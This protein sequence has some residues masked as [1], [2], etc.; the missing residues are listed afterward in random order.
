MSEPV[1]GPQF[2]AQ[3]TPA[4]GEDRNGELLEKFARWDKDLT[5][6]WSAWCEEAKQAYDFVA[7]HQWDPEDQAKME[8]RGKVAVVFN[9]T[10]PTLDAVSGAEIQNRQQ[11]QYYPREMGDTGVSDALTQ[12]AEYVSDECNGDQ[13]DSEAFRDLL[14]CGVGWTDTTPEV[15]GEDT[16]IVKERVDPLTVKADPASRKPCFEDARYIKREYPMSEDE[17]E[18]FRAEIGKPDA[19]GDDGGLEPGKRLTVVNPRQRYTNGMLGDGTEDEVIVCKWQWWEKEPVHLTAMPHPQQPGVTQIMPLSPDQH[20]Q[21]QQVMSEAGKPPLQ[22]KRVTQ[23]VYYYAWVGGGEILDTGPQR[24]KA[25]TLKA[26]TG[27]R[28]RNKGTYYGIVRAMI[29]PAR[30]TNKIFSEILHIVRSNAN[31]GMAMEVGAVEDIQDFERTWASTDEITWL[32][33]GALS[34]PNGPRMIPKTPPPVQPALFQLM[35]FS[36]DMVRKCTGVNEEILGLADREQAGVLEHQRKQAAYGILSP[37]FDALRRYRRDWGKLLLIE[38]RLYLPQDKLVRVVDQGTA[39]Y[40][41]LAETM[42]AGEYDVI[43]DDAPAGP[44]QKAKTMAVLGPW[45]P[46][47]VEGGIIG[48]DAIAEIVPYMDINAALANKLAAAIRTKA[49]PDPQAVALQKAEAVGKLDNLHADT[50]HKRGQAFKAV[51][52]AHADHIH[53]GAEFLAAEQQSEAEQAQPD[54][55]GAASPQQNGQP[56]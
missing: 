30:F 23:K 48:A 55:P 24:E 45:L 50:E 4:E 18:D 21:A 46:A 3:P 38:M 25:F 39:Q 44:N 28:D 22:S 19:A 14:T 7:G 56:T 17:F 53:L 31:G 12:G 33:N 20:A 11:V 42:E 2:D 10:A 26:M 16:Q 51:S 1:T 43:V 40:V 32:G 5:A 15:D 41:A 52:S 8:E 29:D 6:H 35:E 36:R 54:T 34:N 49:Q 37:Y 47:M 27:K 9:L 13:E